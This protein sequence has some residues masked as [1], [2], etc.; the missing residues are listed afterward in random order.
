MAN[1]QYVADLIERRRADPRPDLL[2]DLI[3]AEEAG[4]RL[5]TTEMLH[6]VVSVIM[7]GTDTTRNQLAIGLH[8]LA[9]HPEHW[10]L[11]GDRA[12][13]EFAVEEILR[14]APIGYVLTRVPDVDI[15]IRDLTIPAGTMVVIN[16]GAANRRDDLADAN[17]FDAGRDPSPQHLTFGF[18]LKYC[19]GANL[20]RAEM[21]EALAVLRSRFAS[22][23][24]DGQARFRQVGFIDGP[25]ELPLRF[26]RT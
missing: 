14:F 23:A 4:G 13:L 7:A 11:L 3:V 2:T 19:M 24:H 22:I 25:L 5:S 12:Y 17:A 1:A 15:A 20:A 10:E 6:I 21:V 16:V 9:D 26:G 8:L 18:G